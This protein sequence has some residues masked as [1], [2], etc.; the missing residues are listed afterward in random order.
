MREVEVT[1]PSISVVIPLFNKRV[2]VREAVASALMQD[3]S[4]LEVIVVDDGSTDGGAASLTG[5]DERVRVFRQLNA[6]VS[7]ARNR[8]VK[9]ARGDWVAFLDADDR[10]VQGHLRKLVELSQMHPEAA[11]LCSGYRGFWPDGHTREWLFTE[12]GP[13]L[14]GDFFREQ[15]RALTCVGANAIRREALA[16]FEEPFTVGMSFGEDQDCWFRV[17]ERWPIC[18]V[19]RIGVEIR[20]GYSGRVTDSEDRTQLLPCYERLAERIEQSDFPPHLRHSASVLVA[21]HYLDVA[22]HCARRGEMKHA[23]EV[24]Q[25]RRAKADVRYWITAVLRLCAM[26]L[27]WWFKK[28]RFTSGLDT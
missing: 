24:V 12:L 23:W 9:E 13:G 21:T 2:W 6:G 26:Q 5:F 18:Y 3:W 20:K 22:T 1:S 19:P 28:R 17:A 4:P 10:F 25:S 15:Q 11:I 16:E 7:A 27:G 8:G 14:V